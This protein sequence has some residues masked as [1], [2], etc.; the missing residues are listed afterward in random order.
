MNVFEKFTYHETVVKYI[1]VL[2]SVWIVLY[3]TYSLYDIIKI[4]S[5]QITISRTLLLSNV[6]AWPL[7]KREILG[8][9]WRQHLLRGKS[10]GFIYST[11]IWTHSTKGSTQYKTFKLLLLTSFTLRHLP[12]PVSYKD[13]LCNLQSNDDRMRYS[14]LI[15]SSEPTRSIF[16]LVNE[17]VKINSSLR[18]SVYLSLVCLCVCVRSD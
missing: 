6:H 12:H 16:C 15:I 13:K 5:Y 3:I 18:Q 4:T 7:M 1:D 17:W 14:L 2:A 9:P 10:L 8:V 11:V